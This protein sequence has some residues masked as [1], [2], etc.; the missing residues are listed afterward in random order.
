[1]DY[2]ARPFC[3]LKAIDASE[4]LEETIGRLDPFVAL[5][6]ENQS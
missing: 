3:F 4:A 6:R 5:N 2:F 1:M